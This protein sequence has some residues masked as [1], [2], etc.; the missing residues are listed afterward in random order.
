MPI[1]E[2]VDKKIADQR[3]F[4]PDGREIIFDTSPDACRKFC[5]GEAV[6]GRII[7]RFS[8]SVLTGTSQ[9]QLDNK[10]LYEGVIKGVAIDRFALGEPDEEGEVIERKIPRLWVVWSHNPDKVK[11]LARILTVEDFAKEGF[12]IV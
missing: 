5:G 4:F 9:L 12:M 7:K 10:L 1:A 8:K 11:C 2:L 6:S 3:F